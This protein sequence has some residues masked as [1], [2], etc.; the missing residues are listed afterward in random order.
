MS[1]HF[2]MWLF[3][4]ISNTVERKAALSRISHEMDDLDTRKSS[5]DVQFLIEVVDITHCWPNNNNS[6]I[7]R[8]Q[9]SPTQQMRQISRCMHWLTFS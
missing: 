9:T 1:V 2:G 4:S 8:A 5:T 7:Y 6:D 3:H